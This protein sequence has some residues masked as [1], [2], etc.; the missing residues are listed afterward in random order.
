MA[1]WPLAGRRPADLLIGFTSYLC[2]CVC[3]YWNGSRR[4]TASPPH[5]SCLYSGGL[6]VR[7]ACSDRL[8]LEPGLFVQSGPCGTIEN[9]FGN[10][11]ERYSNVYKAHEVLGRLCYSFEESV[12][13]FA[14]S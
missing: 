5:L 4:E 10:T 13:C 8:L 7:N 12:V 1:E 14:P 6:L 3:S 2:V 11:L 9:R